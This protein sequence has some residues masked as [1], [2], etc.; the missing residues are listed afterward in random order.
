MKFT[1]Q[2][3]G[4]ENHQDNTRPQDPDRLPALQNEGIASSTERI[5]G[6]DD[7]KLEDD[8]SQHG[9]RSTEGQS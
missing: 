9:K 7:D 4:P 2:T 8:V 3:K 1:L 6:H 5:P